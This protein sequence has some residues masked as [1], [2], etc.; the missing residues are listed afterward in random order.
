MSGQLRSVFVDRLQEPSEAEPSDYLR[1]IEGCEVALH[2]YLSDDKEWWLA[3]NPGGAPPGRLN[4][5]WLLWSTYP[6]GPWE[7][8]Y[9]TREQMHHFV[10]ELYYL[11]YDGEERN[12]VHDVRAVDVD[13]APEFVRGELDGRD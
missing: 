6:T 1:A 10:G 2:V 9:C 4:G 13:E 7:L 11:D 3:H 5:P 8:D 12:S